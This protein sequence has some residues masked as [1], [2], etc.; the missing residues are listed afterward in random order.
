MDKPKPDASMIGRVALGEKLI[1]RDTALA[2]YR[3]V[4]ADCRGGDELRAQEPLA[5]EDRDNIWRISGSRQVE[6][7][8]TI[9]YS[10]PICM[11]I[12]KLDGAIVSF[13]G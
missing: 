2:I 5:V 12:S 3:L 10:G 8:E 7:R 11:S 4:I 1:S 13:T 9:A 6:G